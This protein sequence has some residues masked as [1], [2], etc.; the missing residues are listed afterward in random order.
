MILTRENRRTRRKTCSSAT[1]SIT[2]PIWTSLGANPGL[3]GGQPTT[4]RLCYSTVFGGTYFLHLQGVKTQ[5]ANIDNI[6]VSPINR[7]TGVGV[8]VCIAHVLDYGLDNRGSIPGRSRYFSLL[9]A[10]RPSLMSTQL[11]N[12][13]VQP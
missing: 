5:N 2:N 8:A 4:N 12:Q 13:R 3:R 11:L 9:T 7:R 1:L 10:S 6:T